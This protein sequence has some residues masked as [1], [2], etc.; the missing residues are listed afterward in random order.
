MTCILGADFECLTIQRCLSTIADCGNHSDKEK[1]KT[2]QSH[3]WFKQQSKPQWVLS[4]DGIFMW[5]LAVP[6]GGFGGNSPLRLDL[7]QDFVNLIAISSNLQKQLCGFKCDNN[8]MDRHLLNISINSAWEFFITK[9]ALRIIS[10]NIYTTTNAPNICQDGAAMW[11][12]LHCVLSAIYFLTSCKFSISFSL[13][14]DLS[15]K[16]K[17]AE[18]KRSNTVTMISIQATE[19]S[20]PEIA[21]KL[22]KLWKLMKK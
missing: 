22:Q 11:S 2:G 18:Q 9:L 19:Q 16:A 14:N 15:L 4:S 3:R 7:I 1:T 8:T 13:L 5:L 21:L 17:R 10:N 12:V 6:E 20:E